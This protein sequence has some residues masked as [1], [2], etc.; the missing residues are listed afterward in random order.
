[1]TRHHSGCRNCIPLPAFGRRLPTHRGNK[2]TG[3]AKHAPETVP[4]MRAGASPLS[5][6]RCADRPRPSAGL[7]KLIQASGVYPASLRSLSVPDTGAVSGR[8]TP[9][10]KRHGMELLY[11]HGGPP[12]RPLFGHQRRTGHSTRA[13]R[14]RA[15]TQC[16][17]RSAAVADPERPTSISRW[18]ALQLIHR[19]VVFASPPPVG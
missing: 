1:V 6:P 15:L 8:Q 4:T 18:N 17:R 2:A 10:R 12:T 5:A 9:G 7:D 14:R 3:Q 19:G 13:A 16:A 11:R